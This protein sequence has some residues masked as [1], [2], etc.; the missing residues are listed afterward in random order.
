VIGGVAFPIS[1]ENL[2]VTTGEDYCMS[3]IVPQ[4]DGLPGI[5]GVTF[6]KNVVVVHD[7]TDWLE[8]SMEIAS[9]E[10]SQ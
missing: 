4:A 6:M 10:L 7:F 5:L 8:P 1:A 2:I 3:G 9:Y